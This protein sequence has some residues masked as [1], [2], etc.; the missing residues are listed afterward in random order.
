MSLP[1]VQLERLY[2]VI[3]LGRNPAET[4]VVMRVGVRGPTGPGGDAAPPIEYVQSSSS[5]EWIINHNLGW[6]PLIQIFSSGMVEVEADVRHMSD[7][8]ARV[9]FG[10]PVAG[11]ALMR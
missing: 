8:Q 4:V 11:V 9:Y 2:P 10:A 6:R 5:D 1:P 7:N 3:K